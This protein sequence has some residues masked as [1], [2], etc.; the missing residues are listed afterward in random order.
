MI[1]KREEAHLLNLTKAVTAVQSVYDRFVNQ[2]LEEFNEALG[3]INGYLRVQYYA[4]SLGGEAYLQA[5][6]PM[7]AYAEGIN[8]L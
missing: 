8:F 3:R 1:F 6:S 5:I 2:R 4:L 7:D